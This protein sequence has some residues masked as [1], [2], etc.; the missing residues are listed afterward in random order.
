VALWITNRESGTVDLS[1]ID[2]ATGDVRTITANGYDELPSD[3][4]WV[5]PDVIVFDQGGQLHSMQV[6]QPGAAPEPILVNGEPLRLTAFAVG[7]S[8]DA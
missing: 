2:L 6:D 3:V 8:R 1:T 4:H 5:T 7:V